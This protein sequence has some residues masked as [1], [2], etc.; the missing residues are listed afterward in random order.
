V[1]ADIH[2]YTNWTWKLDN[3][4]TLIVGDLCDGETDAY[5]E[6]LRPFRGKFVMPALGNHETYSPDLGEF[7]KT[8]INRDTNYFQGFG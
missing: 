3:N 1:V 7:L 2:Y 6:V 4:L 5:L 8:L